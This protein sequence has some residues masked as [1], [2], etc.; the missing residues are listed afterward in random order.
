M[1]SMVFSRFVEVGRVVVL[2]RGAFT[3]KL[4]VVVEILDHNR[5]LVDG[6]QAMTGVARHV[7]SVGHMTLTD[8]VVPKVTR[9]MT[10]AK[11]C[12]RFNQEGVL[13]K[14]GKSALGL[15]QKRVE[16]RKGMTDFDTFRVK[17]A[18]KKL[19]GAARIKAHAALKKQ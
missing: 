13:R 18:M 2:N 3:G 12:V 19:D 10:H 8:I 5:V 15:R 9:G 14:F 4:A 11:L 16:L 1:Q 17:A 7:A 6:P